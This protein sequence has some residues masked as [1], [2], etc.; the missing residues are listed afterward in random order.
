MGFWPPIRGEGANQLERVAL[1]GA[2]S[3]NT[4][5]GRVYISVAAA[6]VYVYAAYERTTAIASGAHLQPST[7]T[8]I[9]LADTGSYGLTGSIYLKYSA[10]SATIEA[11]PFLATDD[12]LAAERIDIGRYPKTGGT[13]TTF[14]IQ[15]QK[16]R[17]DF[18][19]LMLSRIPPVLGNRSATGGGTLRG[20]TSG[21]WRVNSI[22]DFELVRLQNVESYRQ[23][24]IHHTLAMIFR[25]VNRLIPNEDTQLRVIEEETA[26][27]SAAWAET[28]PLFDED[29]DL[30][31][32]TQAKRFRISRG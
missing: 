6:F 14:A 18:V 24:A 17:E 32:D 3:S 15:H 27:A 31:A 10:A 12:E 21:P 23:W 4:D 13:P 7:W 30:D 2:T 19:R 11:F 22:G 5:K 16:T 9:T 20:V 26:L 29:S 28:L 8:K 25:T 1:S